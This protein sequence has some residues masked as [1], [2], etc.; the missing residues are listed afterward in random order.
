MDQLDRGLRQ[1][2][3]EML[4]DRETRS[5]RPRKPPGRTGCGCFVVLVA[6]LL[7]AVTTTL[8][9]SGL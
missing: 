4:V 8:L 2:T 9:L 1:R 6:L 7:L 3:A 5:K